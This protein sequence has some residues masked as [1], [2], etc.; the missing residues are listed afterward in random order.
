[1]AI[2][3]RPSRGKI[4][5]FTFV[6]ALALI[7]LLL[8]A[9]GALRIFRPDLGN[10]LVRKVSL[11]GIDWYQVNR[12]YLSKYFANNVVLL[13]ELKP[14]LF[15]VAKRPNT[16]RI[17]CLGESTMFGVPYQMSAT[18]PAFVRK[19]LRHLAPDADIEVI[20][21]AASAINS[22]V[23]LDLG[24]EFLA[25]EP[26]AVLV[27]AGHNEYYGP[28]GISAPWIERTF[29]ALIR[30][31]YAA[32]DWYLMKLLDRWMTAPA[33]PASSEVNMMKEVSGG[34]LV[35]LNSPDAAWVTANFERNMRAL[36][37]LFRERHIPVFVSDLTSNLL[38]APFASSHRG[39]VL[40]DDPRVTEAERM[41]RDDSVET[42]R[43]R[44]SAW[45]ADD[46]SDAGAQYWMGRA[47]LA[48]GNPSTA[49]PYL[50]LARDL[51]LLKF[52]APTP[53]EDRLRAVCRETGTPLLPADSLLAAQGPHGLPGSAMYWEH[54][55]P[56]AR[57]YWL[58]ATLFTHALDRAFAADARF[59]HSP[60]PLLPFDRDSLAIAWMDEAYADY[61]MQHLTS[62]WPFTHVSVAPVALSA[63]DTVERML[64][65]RTYTRQ[66]KW[67]DACL[68]SAD[69]FRQTGATALA[70]RTYQALVDDYPYHD[71]AWF[72][73]GK[74]YQDV[75][76]YPQAIAAYRKSIAAG[77]EYPFARINLG[78]LL[79]NEGQFTDAGDQF[80]TA[81]RLLHPDQ[82]GESATAWYGLAAV[83][84]NQN[85]LDAAL[86]SLDSALTAVPSYESA[87]QLRRQILA[88]RATHR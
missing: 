72:Q 47:E 25:Y 41:L 40:M 60:R 76:A 2:E 66:M 12:S 29:P 84:A 31:R 46:S 69:H 10:P 54:L 61:A 42:L 9:E 3:L 50:V 5:L 86:R 17:L 23:I 27:Y 58:I 85:D 52:R 18:I 56:T 33:G 87:L 80:R 39:T 49:R 30:L 62:Q 82:R 71:Y 1:M 35:R 6:P 28:D 73:L 44:A 37:A 7:V 53:T 36:I 64:A 15:R 51:D 81:L 4:V 79:V 20:N 8:L 45:I 78:L 34:A 55:H 68:S 22:N 59:H 77:P 26:D 38:F 48:A 70:I 74:T 32:R 24:R 43:V 13:P 65:F 19:E 14:S 57:G 16:I 83:L 63:A 11:S 75:S 88:Y 21:A 67:G